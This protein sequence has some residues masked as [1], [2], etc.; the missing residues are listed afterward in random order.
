MKLSV[1][2]TERGDRKASI[3]KTIYHYFWM[4][5]GWM[6][7]GH[8]LVPYPAARRGKQ[9]GNGPIDLQRKKGNEK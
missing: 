5:S 8:L 2:M 9:E 1:F 6:D 7:D 3:S 4:L